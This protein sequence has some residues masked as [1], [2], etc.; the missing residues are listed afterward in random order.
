L[1]EDV[2]VEEA[3][4]INDKITGWPPRRREHAACA[5]TNMLYIFGGWGNPER[6]G[7]GAIQLLSDLH[8]FDFDTMKWSGELSTVG[9]IRPS[10]RA[11][12]SLTRVG[13]RCFLFGGTGAE[14]MLN[15]VH[16]FNCD[17]TASV[18]NGVAWTTPRV[19]G[20]A[21]RPRAYFTASAVGDS[22]Y[23]FGGE[24]GGA[25]GAA[26]YHDNMQSTR[27]N[28]LYKF[29]TRLMQ[30]S[31][32]VTQGVRPASRSRHAAIVA[33]ASIFVVGGLQQ[34]RR[35]GLYQKQLDDV[36]EY[37]TGSGQWIGVKD[38]IND[39]R[40]HTQSTTNQNFEPGAVPKRTRFNHSVA[41]Y[42]DFAYFYGGSVDGELVNDI[43][44]FKVSAGHQHQGQLQWMHRHEGTG[45]YYY[46]TRNN[47]G[48][49]G[50]GSGG[51]DAASSTYS[52]RRQGP[53]AVRRVDNGR[54]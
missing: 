47:A 7:Y 14:G 44:I 48:L 17:T 2:S 51:M 53:G 26:P 35:D 6:N 54:R 42:G 23:I 8:A 21:P 31:S 5:T 52:A 34:L 36:F 41:A 25:P 19:T 33:G 40:V 24:E 1:K 4:Y 39:E 9:G 37:R 12:H 30:W 43:D 11:G 10:R 22:I 49:T 18:R 16:Y 28:D 46:E 15:D 32:P 45:G 3:D 20:D 29:D 38:P 27:Y 50:H 13:D